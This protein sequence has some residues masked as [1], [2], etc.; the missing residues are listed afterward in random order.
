MKVICWG[1]ANAHRGHWGPSFYQ[2]MLRTIPEGGGLPCGAA[3]QNDTLVWLAFAVLFGLY[4]FAA[5]VH[6]PRDLP[7]V[8]LAFPFYLLL[9]VCPHQ[10]A[11]GSI[12]SSP[13]RPWVF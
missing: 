12:Q 1:Q 9:G 13:C 2:T 10:G 4:P 11:G 8:I 7:K 6:S 3:P 5:L